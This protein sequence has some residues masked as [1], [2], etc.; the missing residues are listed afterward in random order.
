M[1]K[2]NAVHGQLIAFAPER[3][4]DGALRVAS[5]AKFH[6]VAY[7]LVAI[8]LGPSGYSFTMLRLVVGRVMKAR[9]MKFSLSDE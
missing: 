8:V 9:L 4:L 6:N 7:R 3:L 1:N 5:C 2:E